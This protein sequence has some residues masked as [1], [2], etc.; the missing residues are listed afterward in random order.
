VCVQIRTSTLL[1][2]YEDILSLQSLVHRRSECA[3]DVHVLYVCVVGVCTNNI[4]YITTIHNY[5]DILQWTDENTIIIVYGP[6]KV[7]YLP[8]DRRPV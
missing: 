5:E 2:N 8:R 7:Q 6:V 4:T 3:C 1:H